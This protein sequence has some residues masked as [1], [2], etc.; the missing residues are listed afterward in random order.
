MISHCYFMCD[1]WAGM[2]SLTGGEILGK[3]AVLRSG[4]R[5]L[6]SVGSQ[7]PLQNHVKTVTEV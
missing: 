7:S 3:R 6:L 5:Q 1:Q 2:G 4:Q